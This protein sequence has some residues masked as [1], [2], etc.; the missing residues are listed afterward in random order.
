VTPYGVL[1]I[2]I[3]T[4][5]RKTRKEKGNENQ[6]ERKSREES[7]LVSARFL[8][9]YPKRRKEKAMKTKTNVKAGK[10]AS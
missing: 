2:G 7:E 3:R 6:D 4:A 9:A 8:S 10:R 1:T 5:L